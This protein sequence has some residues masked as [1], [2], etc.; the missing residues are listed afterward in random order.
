MVQNPNATGPRRIVRQVAGAQTTAR[1]AYGVSGKSTLLTLDQAW[2]VANGSMA[3]IRSTF[4][5]GQSEPLTLSEEP[6]RTIV[7]GQD[8]ELAGLFNEL[9]A[10][11][12]IILSGERADIPGVTG[13]KVSELMMVSG[14]H[15]DF[16]PQLPGDKTHTTLLMATPM[17]Y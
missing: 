3:T 12:W 2:R 13:V 8:I 4:V 15:H 16:D 14:L 7:E 6:I 11:R 17:A 1:T 9:T 10:G 5:Y